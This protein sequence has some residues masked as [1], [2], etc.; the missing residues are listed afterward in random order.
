SSLA[1]AAVHAGALAPGEQGVVKVTMLPGQSSYQGSRR[2]GVASGLWDSWNASFRVEPL[3]GKL[4]VAPATAAVPAVPAVPPPALAD[5]Y[6]LFGYRSRVGETFYF[7]VTGRTAAT[8]W[9][10]DV[11]TDDS[12]LA[13]AAVHA[14]VLRPGQRGTVKV[15]ILPGQTAYA[16][17]L[18]NGIRSTRYRAWG[19]SYR[20]EPARR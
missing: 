5:E 2:N 20:V 9:G 3:D 17:S 4:R 12:P 18:R 15:T 19:G 10:T 7:T 16:G 6:S 8:I 14:G 11:Y 1:A 13:V